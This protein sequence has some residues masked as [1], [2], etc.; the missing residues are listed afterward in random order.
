MY[1]CHH[2]FLGRPHL[3]N[4]EPEEIVPRL[5]HLYT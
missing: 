4:D 5:I 3:Y 2:V 1:V